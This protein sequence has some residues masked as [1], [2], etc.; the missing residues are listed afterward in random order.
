MEV[1]TGA[2]WDFMHSAYNKG[3]LDEILAI[4]GQFLDP[5]MDLGEHL[6]NLEDALTEADFAPFEKMSRE[7]MV[8]ML[9]AL[10]QD[11]AMEGLTMFI[12]SIRSLVED[13]DVK[14]HLKV[15]GVIGKGLLAL[16]PVVV[17]LVPVIAKVYG[18]VVLK[19]MEHDLGSKAASAI[20]SACTA[21]NADP[22]IACHV[23]SDLFAGVDGEAFRMAMDTI[24]G[25]FLDQRPPLAGWTAATVVKRARKRLEE[26]R[27][28][29][30]VRD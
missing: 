22:R 25:G 21:I 16:K 4:V 10:A 20:N 6:G 15:V 9:R 11:D 29:R 30:H 13:G 27:R 14:E 28:G 3:V 2:V 12:S 18:P 24:V 19:F 8:P 23:I 26:R 17:A 5:G 1:V 7:V